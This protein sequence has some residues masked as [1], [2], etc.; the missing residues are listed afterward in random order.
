MPRIPGVGTFYTCMSISDLL[1]EHKRY[2]KKPGKMVEV[3]FPNRDSELRRGEE[4]SMLVMP[5]TSPLMS[6]C[7][8]WG[9][10]G[11]AAAGLAP[12]ECDRPADALAGGCG[13]SQS[14]VRARRAG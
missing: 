3:P 11:G 9:L 14:R 7:V 8:E 10:S 1:D 13:L 5:A 12:G 2:A 6:A 4:R